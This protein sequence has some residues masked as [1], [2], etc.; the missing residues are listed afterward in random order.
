[1]IIPSSTLCVNFMFLLSFHGFDF[2]PKNQPSKIQICGQTLA[3]KTLTKHFGC[4][5][6]FISIINEYF[7]MYLSKHNWNRNVC[8]PNNHQYGST[9]VRNDN[10]SF[11]LT[12][13]CFV[14]LMLS[15]ASGMKRKLTII[16]RLLALLTSWGWLT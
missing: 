3:L 14:W 2:S 9:L 11:F 1:M 10:T 6:S 4:L 13:N 7:N 15:M 8:L 16:N 12:L 5:V